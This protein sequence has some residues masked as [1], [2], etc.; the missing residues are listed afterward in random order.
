MSKSMYG[1]YESNLGMC[2][3]MNSMFESMYSM[4]SMKVYMVCLVSTF[5]RIWINQ[6]YGC[7]SWLVVS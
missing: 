6:T 5:S 7:Q 4:Y 1:M 2:E 3:C